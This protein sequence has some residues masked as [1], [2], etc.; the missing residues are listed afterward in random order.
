MCDID[1]LRPGY[2][3]DRLELAAGSDEIAACFD[4][5]LIIVKGVKTHVQPEFQFD[6]FTSRT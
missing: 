2:V 6:T 4:W 3:R 5:L 1:A